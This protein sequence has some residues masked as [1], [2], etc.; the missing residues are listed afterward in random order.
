[1]KKIKLVGVSENTLK[2]WGP[3]WL[4]GPCAEV[5]TFSP[6]QAPYLRWS[7]TGILLR[8]LKRPL[9]PSWEPPPISPRSLVALAPQEGGNWGP[10][11][12]S[13][14]GL[15]QLEAA[16]TLSPPEPWHS[17]QLPSHPPA[18]AAASWDHLAS[19]LPLFPLLPAAPLHCLGWGQW[20]E[21]LQ[22]CL[23]S[24]VLVAAAKW[25]SDLLNPSSN[26]AHFLRQGD[27]EPQSSAQLD[28]RH[29]GQLS[30]ATRST[31]CLWTSVFLALHQRC[32]MIL[33]WC[34]L[35]YGFELWIL[36]HCK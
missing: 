9:L 20:L 19:C 30:L 32:T 10:L 18:T 12:N 29:W 17:H 3:V 33:G 16:E 23:H 6:N 21:L 15:R 35:N 31:S 4:E 22:D 24:K 11:E 13:R 7:G 34:N 36:N 8:E 27:T 5:L 26:I 28:P 1:M 2:A 25:H 14:S